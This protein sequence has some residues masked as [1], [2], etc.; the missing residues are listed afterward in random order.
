MRGRFIGL[1]AVVTDTA[2]GR[3][4]NL[5]RF[6]S[7]VRTPSPCPDM[8]GGRLRRREIYLR[9]RRRRLP[10]D[11]Q[12]TVGLL[13][14]RELGCRR[15]DRRARRQLLQLRPRRHHHRRRH[16]RH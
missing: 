2:G 11:T 12:S 6:E 9:F 10:A 7:P 14:A 3:P 15:N 16:R 4:C 5:R 13:S 8:L 1:Y